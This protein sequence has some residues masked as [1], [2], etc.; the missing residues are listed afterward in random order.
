MTVSKWLFAFLLLVAG[1]LLAQAPSKS[2]YDQHLAFDPLF[3]PSNGNEYRTGGGE[4]GSKY[5]QNRADY[6]INVELDDVKRTITAEAVVT[7]HNASPDAL[8]S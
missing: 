3:Y 1:N 7:Y 4:P 2:N 8:R 5:W 6:D